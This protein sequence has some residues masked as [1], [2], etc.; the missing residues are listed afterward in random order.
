[1]PPNTTTNFSNSSNSS[2]NSSSSNSSNTCSTDPHCSFLSITVLGSVLSYASIQ[3]L[4][5]TEAPTVET[6]EPTFFGHMSKQ[7]A[8]STHNL[9]F[10]ALSQ[11]AGSAAKDEILLTVL[12][13]PDSKV[14]LESVPVQRAEKPPS[15]AAADAESRL[16]VFRTTVC[17]PKGL[18]EVTCELRIGEEG[19]RT[20]EF[21]G[22]A[23]QLTKPPP[24][25]PPP[26][27][28]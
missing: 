24:P 13:G 16:A 5:S 8:K 23:H 6:L 18:A 12:A 9:A 3:K 19:G 28:D 25:P 14:T 7:L 20:K 10:K 1:M 26:S 17:I 2:S 22:A 15:G 27:S 4:K 21:G 11:T